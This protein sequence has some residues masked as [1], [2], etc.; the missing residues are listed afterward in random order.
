MR[1]RYKIPEGRPVAPYYLI[2]PFVLVKNF[3]VGL[4]SAVR[5]SRTSRLR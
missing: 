2:H 1:H 3:F 5:A 4:A